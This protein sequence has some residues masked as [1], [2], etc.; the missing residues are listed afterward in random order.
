M[1]IP[2][3]RIRSLGTTGIEVTELA[4]GTAPLAS[5]FW[6]NTAATAVATATAALDAGIGLCDTAPLYG[7]GEAEER[8]GAAL[9]ARPD[10]EVAVATK[11]GRTVVDVEGGGRDVVADHGRDATLRQLEASLGRLG[12]DHVDIVHVHDPEDHLDQAIEEQFAALADLRDQGVVRAISVGTNVVATAL[13]FLR[14]A[15]PDLVMVAGRLTLLDRAA[16]AELIPELEARSVPMFAAGVYNSGVL[17]RPVEGSWF[18]YAPASREVLERVLAMDGICR[19]A[20]IELRAAAMQFPL[21]FGPVA[22]VVV[23]M[24]SPAEVAENVALMGAEVS[25]EV[26]TALDQL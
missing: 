18:D 26:W 4:F 8:L 3:L 23:G 12:R 2:P 10:L 6:G 14:R 5:A 11:V 24:A 13:A 7:V 1:T 20:G 15:D 16:A 21:R 22:S 25:D 9:A 19:D 17:A